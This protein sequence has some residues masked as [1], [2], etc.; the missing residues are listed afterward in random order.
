MLSA[1]EQ[2]LRDQEVSR[3]LKAFLP[4]STTNALK[5]YFFRGNVPMGLTQIA[6]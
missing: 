6:H 4:S 5:K 1:E 3:E 2:E